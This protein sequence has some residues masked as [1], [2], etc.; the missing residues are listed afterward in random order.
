MCEH[1]RRPWLVSQTWKKL[2]FATEIPGTCRIFIFNF[3][4]EGLFLFLLKDIIII[5]FYN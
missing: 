1:G 3:K 5:I 4:S 2:Y